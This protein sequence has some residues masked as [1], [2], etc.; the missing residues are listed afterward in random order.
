MKPKH[1]DSSHLAKTCLR[2]LLLCLQ[3]PSAEARELWK[4]FIHSVTE[5]CLNPNKIK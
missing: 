3:V 1:L 5:V 4:G 2:A